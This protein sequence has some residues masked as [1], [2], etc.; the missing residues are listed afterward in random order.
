[1]DEKGLTPERKEDEGGGMSQHSF[2]SVFTLIES[3][4]Q[5]DHVVTP[6]IYLFIPF[7]CDC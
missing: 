3:I 1:M 4:N 6:K 7:S 5:L 2:V